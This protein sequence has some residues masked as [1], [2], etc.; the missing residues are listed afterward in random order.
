M[1]LI[2]TKNEKDTQF[3]GKLRPWDAVKKVPKILGNR[4]TTPEKQKRYTNSLELG[5]PRTLNFEKLVGTLKMHFN[6][7]H[8]AKLVGQYT[9]QL[10]AGNANIRS[11]S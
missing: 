6:I 5:V 1:H 4:Q 11:T 3:F 9:K 2:H 8:K 7:V 10:L